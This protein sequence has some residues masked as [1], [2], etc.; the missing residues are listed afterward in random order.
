[1]MTR[2]GKNE[3]VMFRLE[4]RVIADVSVCFAGICGAAEFSRKESTRD[5]LVDFSR[6]F[7]TSVASFS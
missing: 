3:F 2:C 1:M 4:K 5:E 7:P 6:V